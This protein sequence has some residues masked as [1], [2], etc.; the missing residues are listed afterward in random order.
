MLDLS[1]LDWLVKRLIGGD[2]FYGLHDPEAIIAKGRELDRKS[3]YMYGNSYEK[4]ARKRVA[5]LRVAIG[6]HD[7][8]GSTGRSSYA[9]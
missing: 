3:S 6:N 9:H 8:G 4:E 5:T 2:E 1:M 7:G